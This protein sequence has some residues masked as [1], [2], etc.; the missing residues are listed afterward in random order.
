MIFETH[1]HYDDAQFE[2]DREELLGKMQ[3]AG[4]GRII[5]VGASIESSKTSL[6]IAAKQE[7]IYAAV[8]V[9]QSDIEGLNEDTLEW[10]RQQT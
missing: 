1:A 6:E 5:N 3:D 4:I 7:F 2:E 9:H 8:G 10:L